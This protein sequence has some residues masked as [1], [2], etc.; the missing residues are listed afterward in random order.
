MT[1]FNAKKTF[2]VYKNYLETLEQEG[3]MPYS[4]VQ[5]LLV[6]GF[7]E[8]IC[9]GMFNEAVSEDDYKVLVNCYDH[10]AGIKLI[11]YDVYTKNVQLPKKPT[12][13]GD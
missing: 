4:A 1:D 9:S 13:T 3:Y 10:I 8:D 6:L 12:V 7:M 5:N 2:E 11:P